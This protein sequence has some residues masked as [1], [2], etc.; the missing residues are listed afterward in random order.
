MNLS[1]WIKYSWLCH[2]RQSIRLGDIPRSQGVRRAVRL[3]R[4]RLEEE[5]LE[6]ERQAALALDGDD[7]LVLL[8][9]SV[10]KWQ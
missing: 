3:D 2:L 8:I 10:L 7:V 6:G 4:P 1:C 5:P 9:Q